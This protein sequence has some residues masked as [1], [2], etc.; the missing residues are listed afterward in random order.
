[1][2]EAVDAIDHSAVD[3]AAAAAQHAELDLLW[4]AV[5]ELPASQRET[6]LLRE[7]RGLSYD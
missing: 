5:A 1:V 7:I 6:L 3:P 2:A 4:E